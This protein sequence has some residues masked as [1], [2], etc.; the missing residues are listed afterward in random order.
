MDIDWDNLAS[1]MKFFI[2]FLIF[3]LILAFVIQIWSWVAGFKG[4]GAMFFS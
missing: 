4:L 1:M 2:Y 3:L